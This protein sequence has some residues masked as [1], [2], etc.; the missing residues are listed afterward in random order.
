[1]DDW[2]H[3]PPVPLATRL[4]RRARGLDSGSRRWPQTVSSAADGVLDGGE[5]RRLSQPTPL[6]GGCRRRLSSCYRHENQYP[7]DCRTAVPC[8]GDPAAARPPDVTAGAGAASSVLTGASSASPPARWV[9]LPS[10][11][12]P[13]C[14]ANLLLRAAR[15]CGADSR[16]AES[17]NSRSAVR[18]RF[19]YPC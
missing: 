4:C 12:F 2:G 16:C 6:H 1:M 5:A 15:G 8:R 14:G 18:S 19:P 9:A 10:V 11:L 13:D 7:T 3:S 17:S